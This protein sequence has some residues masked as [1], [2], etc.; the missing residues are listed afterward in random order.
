MA[1]RCI[2]PALAPVPAYFFRV[3]M[4]AFRGGPTPAPQRF[5]YTLCND[6][7]PDSVHLRRRTRPGTFWSGTRS[8]A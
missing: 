1:V 8:A 3:V 6:P 5:R 4:P 2:Q 7:T